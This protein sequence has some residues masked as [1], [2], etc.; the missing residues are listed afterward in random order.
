MAHGRR[1]IVLETKGDAALMYPEFASPVA[2]YLDPGLMLAPEIQRVVEQLS[3]ATIVVV[4][5][6]DAIAPQSQGVPKAPEIE[7][8]MKSFD[9]IFAGKY[10]DVYRRRDIAAFSH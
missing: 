5:V 2:L 3:G 4:P 10:V 1:A 7:R 9:L 6:S 8:V